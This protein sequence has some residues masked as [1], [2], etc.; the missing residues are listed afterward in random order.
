M[1][2]LEEDLN[3]VKCKPKTRI[4]IVSSFIPKAVGLGDV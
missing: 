2:D 1:N 3:E 4:R